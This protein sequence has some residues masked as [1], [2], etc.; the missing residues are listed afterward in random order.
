MLGRALRRISDCGLRISDPCH[1]SIVLSAAGLRIAAL[2][3]WGVGYNVQPTALCGLG[4]G[5]ITF[6][7]IREILGKNL[8]RYHVITF[9]PRSIREIRAI[10][11]EESEFG[12]TQRAD[13]QVRP[14]PHPI[15]GIQKFVAKLSHVITFPRSH[16]I[17]FPRSPRAPFVKFVQFV[18]KFSH[19]ITFARYHVI[20]FAPRLIREI[21]AIRGKI[22]PASAIDFLLLSALICVNLRPKISPSPD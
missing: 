13:T 8:P 3:G 19:V 1:P 16:V 18:A 4:S 20:T 22:L 15:Y 14:Y 10:R 9:A 12:Q 17:T 7:I 11:G 6:P 21:R 5:I 2:R